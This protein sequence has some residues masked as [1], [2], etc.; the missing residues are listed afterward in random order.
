MLFQLQLS[1]S[2]E[3]MWLLLYMYLKSTHF[4]SMYTPPL[5]FLIFLIFLLGASAKGSPKH[6]SNGLAAVSFR[7]R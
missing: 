5:N 1:R 4:A 3:Q 6:C 7:L 2:L